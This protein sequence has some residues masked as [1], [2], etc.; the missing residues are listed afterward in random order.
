MLEK[1]SSLSN[2]DRRLVSPLD[3]RALAANGRMLRRLNSGENMDLELYDKR[4]LNRN[5]RKG[6][7]SQ[8]DVNT[9][10]EGL[11]D[12]VD[13]VEEVPVDEQL[14]MADSRDGSRIK[15]ADVSDEDEAALD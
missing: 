1:R 11:E 10:L 2:L 8:N 7:L 14:L 5:T 15:A 12:M 4:L 3:C 6:K 9:M 13:N